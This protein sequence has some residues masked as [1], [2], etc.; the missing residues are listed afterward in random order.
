MALGVSG[1]G[2]WVLAT[3]PEIRPVDVGM[4]LSTVAYTAGG[5]LVW[6]QRP[7]QRF[8]PLLLLAGA[9]IA[10]PSLQQT[11]IGVLWT[12]GAAL[13]S[14]FAFVVA[15]TVLRFPRGQLVSRLDRALVG[16]VAVVAIVF[17]VAI[18]TL[19]HPRA[20]GCA[21]CPPG[22]NVILIADRPDL[23]ARAVEPLFWVIAVQATV[24][25][26]RLLWKVRAATTPA[27]R[28]L[29]PVAVPAGAWF[30]MHAATRVIRLE[31]TEDIPSYDGV[32]AASTA[33][34]CLIPAGVLT[35]LLRARARRS[36]VGD[37][38][39]ELD[40]LPST[41]RVRDA[42]VRTLGDP[43]AEVG[44]WM[45]DTQRYVTAE[46]DRLD[47]VAADGRREVT[48]VAGRGQPLAAIVHDAALRDE[49]A[50]MEAVGAAARFAVENERLQAETLARLEEVRESRARIVRAGDD[51]RRRIE[52]NLHDGAQQRLI[53][54]SLQLGMLSG[55]PA[56]E[57]LR[58]QLAAAVEEVRLALTELRE[59]AQGL[60]PAVL[61]DE[62]LAPAVEYLAERA[63]VPVTLE[64]PERRFAEQCEVTAYFVVSEA[65][66]NVAKHA[67]GARARVRIA[68]E[69]RELRV[70]VSDD[71]PG[72]ASADAGSGLR[73]LA[74][75]VAAANGS[76]RVDS[77]HDGGTR[78]TAVIPCG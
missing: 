4:L 22:M 31:V 53:A 26:A 11:R 54:V 62:G 51:E 10:L 44:F 66:A 7:D 40:R 73:G 59:L 48:Y 46:G 38:V 5:L 1:W 42:V 16:S 63:T 8:G 2:A 47:L 65:L 21:G 78:L 15:Y 36:K 9:C 75:R 30:L 61:R 14:V 74:D 76:L 69:G 25:G 12:A 27:R 39:V 67:P 37:L 6:W 50:L 71:G 28:I 56:G 43:S 23:L 70:E 60:H 77:P 24:I 29:W 49:P 33:L 52:R 68:E 72:G 35:G 32:V 17:P 55:S 20:F 64:V 41:E 18:T 19:A 13:D 3:F 34:L 57:G 58:P 45:P